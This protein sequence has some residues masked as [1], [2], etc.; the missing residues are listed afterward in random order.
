M[1][2]GI[3]KWISEA[4]EN[5]VLAATG[6]EDTQIN[7]NNNIQIHKTH[8]YFTRYYG[9]IQLCNYTK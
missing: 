2:E 7:I 3:L 5:V 8:W 1:T 6:G 9:S 4:I